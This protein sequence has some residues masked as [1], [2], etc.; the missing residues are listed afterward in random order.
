MSSPYRTTEILFYG[1]S[2]QNM[3]DQNEKVD[4]LDYISSMYKIKLFDKKYQKFNCENRSKYFTENGPVI[5]QLIPEGRSCWI[6]FSKENNLFLIEQFI[7]PGYMTPKIILLNNL[8]EMNNNK[9]EKKELLFKC[10]LIYKESRLLLLISDIINLMNINPFKRILF[11]LYSFWENL[12]IKYIQI[13]ILRIFTRND[14]KFISKF[15]ASIQYRCKGI[16]FYFCKENTVENRYI[17]PIIFIYRS[18]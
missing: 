12:Q 15:I 6:F 13:E 14:I 3:I 9:T 17:D 11:D 1:I 2:V 7:R 5:F 16:L 8:I 4:L 18:N 10:Y